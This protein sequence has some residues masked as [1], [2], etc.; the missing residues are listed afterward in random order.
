MLDT[1]EYYLL[2]AAFAI[3][4]LWWLTQTIVYN[5]DSTTYVILSQYLAGNSEPF[6][7]YIFMR[8]IG[9]PLL[10]LISGLPYSNS[11]NV[12]LLLQFAM[13]ISMP[14]LLYRSVNLVI[15]NSRFAFGCAIFLILSLLPFVYSKAIMSEQVFMFMIF[16]VAYRLILY[17]RTETRKDLIY[18]I[19]SLIILTLIRPSANLF[20]ILIFLHSMLFIRKHIATWLISLLLFFTMMSCISTTLLLY[21]TVPHIQ[22]TIAHKINETLFYHLYLKGF[23]EADETAAK[24]LYTAQIK[25]LTRQYAINTRASQPHLLPKSIFSPLHTDL[26]LFINQVF[27]EPNLLYYG[28]LRSALLATLGSEQYQRPAGMTPNINRFMAATSYE[29]LKQH[30]QY[31]IS[32][33]KT[34]LLGGGSS[35]A[36]QMLFYHSYVELPTLAED[37]TNK[38]NF[39]PLSGKQNNKLH[40]SLEKYLYAYPQAWDSMQPAEYF[41]NYK[42]NPQGLLQ[43]SIVAKPNFGSVWFMWNAM[44]MMFSPPEVPA[45]FM[46]AALETLGKNKETTVLMYIND[47]LYFMFGSSSDYYYGRQRISLLSPQMPGGEDPFLSSSPRYRMMKLEAD[48]KPIFKL[49]EQTSSKFFN[50]EAVLW[51]IIKLVTSLIIACGFLLTFQT[52]QHKITT[53]LLLIWLCHIVVSSVFGEPISR[54]AFQIMPI[55]ILLAS[56]ILYQ[57]RNFYLLTSTAGDKN[58]KAISSIPNNG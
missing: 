42:D 48:N 20:F 54:Y 8:T 1:K 43:Y 2:I 53:I 7:S 16:F 12:L 28:Y 10:M 32:Y 18:L 9:Y 51:T 50:L 46:Q 22:G 14:I 13:A 23:D 40:R 34:Y 41:A 52:K 31:L 45:L 49:T 55:N 29:I 27:T 38:S 11:F 19:A 5:P 39:Y 3:G 58:S 30:P 6:N 44:D 37:K 57:L 56:I 36:G 24:N 26:D 15:N 21:G 35:F 33:I 4:T 17:Y 25:Y 47:I